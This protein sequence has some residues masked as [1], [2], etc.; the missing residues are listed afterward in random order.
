M[1]TII[2]WAM[3]A[4]PL[5]YSLLNTLPIIR[6]RHPPFQICNWQ[7]TSL[8]FFL[9]FFIF[10]TDAT[11]FSYHLT[12][13]LSISTANRQLPLSIS[14]PKPTNLTFFPY[15]TVYC[16]QWR[17]VFFFMNVLSFVIF[18]SRE[19]F[20]IFDVNEEKSSNVF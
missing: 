14:R 16:S 17:H 2:I 8:S 19:V 4:S 15:K 18:V 1:R 12:L 11:I 3:L 9:F 5:S 10:L 6:P 7:P 13:S 20:F